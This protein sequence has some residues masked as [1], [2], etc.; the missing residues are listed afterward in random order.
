MT[1]LSVRITSVTTIQLTRAM[2]SQRPCKLVSA[3]LD[4]PVSEAAAGSDERLIDKLLLAAFRLIFCKNASISSSIRPALA[5]RFHGE[6]ICDYCLCPQCNIALLLER[7]EARYG[8]QQWGSHRCAN[9]CLGD[10]MRSG[11][12]AW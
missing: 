7:Y 4:G 11:R 1:A 5:A 6:A 2:S 8:C 12:P 9:T 10:R 3:L